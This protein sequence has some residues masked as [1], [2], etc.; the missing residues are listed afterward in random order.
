[1]CITFDLIKNRGELCYGGGVLNYDK[2]GNWKAML[3]TQADLG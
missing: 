1:M 3:I 2:Y